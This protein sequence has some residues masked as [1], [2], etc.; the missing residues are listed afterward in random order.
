[1]SV[2]ASSSARSPSPAAIAFSASARSPRGVRDQPS[3]APRAAST[4]RSTSPAEQPGIVAIV[5]SV[6]GLTTG[7]GSA[8]DGSTHSPP[9]KIRRL[10]I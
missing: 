6:V 1:V 9:M 3:K 10:F 8:P 5:S 4:A 7:R 2:S